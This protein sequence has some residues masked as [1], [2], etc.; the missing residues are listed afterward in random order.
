MK[1]RLV[2]FWSVVPGLIL[3][4]S[5]FVFD[6]HAA[7]EKEVRGTMRELVR[8]IY[9]ERNNDGIWENK[10]GSGHSFGG[11][12]SMAVLALLS[13]GESYQNP[14]IKPAIEW[15]K[16]ANLTGTYAIAM[17]AHV[18][19]KLPNDF[20]RYLKRDA[21]W[22]ERKGAN[23]HGLFRYS[24]RS[25]AGSGFDATNWDNSANQYGMLG[26]WEASKRGVRV[27]PAFW[28]KAALHFIKSQ[29]A[30]GGWCYTAGQKSY[31]SMTAAGLTILSI[32]D[33]ELGKGDRKL[34]KK[35]K[36]SME[37]GLQWV[38]RH[39]NGVT[40]INR[41]SYQDYYL[42]G[43]ERVGLATGIKTFGG[44]DW[45]EKGAD[46]YVG[47]VAGG[48]HRSMQISD[49]SFASTLR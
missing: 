20:K 35:I 1:Q 47:V 7:T 43:M 15:L 41:G 6:V 12:T 18:W 25:A 4:F 31:G 3:L 36:E 42:Y 44:Q 14:K 37:R 2:S 23:K 19:A 5:C 45:Y 34:K 30:D 11:P 17:R 24:A 39:F 38:N 22:L 28:R 9:S 13:A 32:C 8:Y 21:E 40:N 16:Q 46:H 26:L 10:H 49:V 29:G 48:S 27:K 33:Q